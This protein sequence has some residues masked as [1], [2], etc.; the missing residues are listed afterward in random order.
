MLMISGRDAA[1][2]G[3]TRSTT[4]T[5]SAP[6]PPDATAVDS[7]SSDCGF[8][9]PSLALAAKECAGLAA[10]LVQVRGEDPGHCVPG[11]VV[12]RHEFHQPGVLEM[13]RVGFLVS[14]DEQR[15]EAIQERQVAHDGDR[16]L[17]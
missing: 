12:F 13:D 17:R 3:R 7:L 11:C 6:V 1:A 9:Y 2:S 5:E 4:A 16:T 8:T 10:V 15:C 14:S